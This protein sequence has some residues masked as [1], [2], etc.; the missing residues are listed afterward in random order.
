M[1]RKPVFLLP[2]AILAA[3][4]V[5]TAGC[6]SGGEKGGQTEAIPVKTLTLQPTDGLSGRNYVGTVEASKT[7]VL[8]CSYSGTLK[9]LRAEEELRNQLAVIVLLS[10]RALE[11]AANRKKQSRRLVKPLFLHFDVQGC[12]R[13]HSN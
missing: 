4:A 1:N 2:A 8:S 12:E 6:S 10:G 7:A 11:R 13:F 3:A 9:E 5:I